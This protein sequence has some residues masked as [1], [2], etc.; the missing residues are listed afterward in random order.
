MVS[1]EN[2]IIS[3]NLFLSGP[4]SLQIIFVSQQVICPARDKSGQRKHVFFSITCLLQLVI[5]LKRSIFVHKLP[6]YLVFRLEHK[7]LTR[8]RLYRSKPEF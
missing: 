3:G 5:K 4:A 6:S 1:Q 7:C 2:N 8:L